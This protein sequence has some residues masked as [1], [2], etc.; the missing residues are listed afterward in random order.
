M[1]T[2]LFIFIKHHFSFLWRLIED[3]NGMLFKLRYHDVDVI[4]K[5]VLNGIQLEH[6]RFGLVTE[7][8][9]PYLCTF[10]NRQTDGYIKHFKPHDFDAATLYHLL[11]NPAFIMMKAISK[12]DGMIIGYFFLRCFFMGKAFHGLIVDGHSSGKG[13]GTA[14]WSSSMLISNRLNIKMYATISKNN[15][16]S[17][18]SCRMGTSVNVVKPLPNDYLLIECNIKNT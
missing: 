14:M 16:A 15:E 2:P 7:S 18:R 5:D 13:V 6:F 17:L 10:L 8:D 1:I 4:A 12:T 3:V 11:Y 9:I